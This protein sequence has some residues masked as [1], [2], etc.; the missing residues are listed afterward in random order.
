MK[1]VANKETREFQIGIWLHLLKE[2]LYEILKH[3]E[4]CDTLIYT[5]LKT[6]II[7]DL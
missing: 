7:S 1:K 5:G 6:I 3:K 2:V 4:Q